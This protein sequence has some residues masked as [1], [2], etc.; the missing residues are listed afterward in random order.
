MSRYGAHTSKRVTPQNQQAR[1]DQVANS[2]GGFAFQADKWTRLDRF[3][4][5]GAEG[6]TYYIGELQLTKEN[7]GV[8]DTCA[9]DDHERLINQIVAI[10]EEGRAPRQTPCI[11]SLAYLSGHPDV[12]IRRLALAAMPRVCRTG[13]HLFQFLADVEHFRGWGRLLRDAI[14]NWYLAKDV[15]NLAYQVVKYQQR[16]GESHTGALRRAHTRSDDPD[17]REVLAYAAQKLLNTDDEKVDE[18][19][20]HLYTAVQAG[21]NLG[22]WLTDPKDHRQVLAAVAAA[23]KAQ[24]AD[25]IVNL[26][27]KHDLVRECIPTEFLNSSKVWEALLV[28]MPMGAM[29]RNLAK[30]TSIGLIA[31]MSDASREICERLHN[32]EA[33]R[34]A[35]IHPIAVLLAMTTYS[36]GHGLRGK[37]TWNAVPQLVDALDDA[38]Y[39]AFKNVEPTGKRWFLGLDVSGSM[40]GGLAGTSLT[41]AQGAGAMAMVTMRSEKEWYCHGFATTF[42]DLTTGGRFKD[43]WSGRSHT[44]SGISAKSKLN[45]VV[46]TMFAH[47]M[48]GTDCAVP[49]THALKHKIPVDVFAVYTDSETWF[50][51]IHPHQALEQYRQKMGIGAKLIV[52]GMVANQFTIADPNDPGMLDVVGF[53]ASVPAVMADFVR[54]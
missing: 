1:E 45:E 8:L 7:A 6:G 18:D 4:I 35:R 31:P 39:L 42:V 12:V 38:F 15:R 44:V 26:I 20:L 24:S 37:L 32:Q 13:M 5:L 48:G 17:M 49:M 10:S 19:K 28:K 43:S 46:D 2:A 40:A 41:C 54:H 50:G 22:N 29:V 52:V 34:K 36:S 16:G 25:E 53:D 14:S 9:K 33:I 11:F 23:R 27:E 47:T 3:L 21:P 30:M 51:G